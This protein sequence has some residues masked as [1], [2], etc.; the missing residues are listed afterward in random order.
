M[1]AFSQRSLLLCVALLGV[2]AI[3]ASSAQ[4]IT[5]TPTRT[6]VEGRARNPELRY[7][8]SAFRCDTG[9]ATGTTSDPASA[10]LSLTVAFRDNCNSFGFEVFVECRGNMTLEA[11]VAAGGGAG[12]GVLT[13][14]ADFTCSIRMTGICTITIRG[15]QNRLPRGE[16][17]PGSRAGETGTLEARVTTIEGREDPP[18]SVFC[19]DSDRRASFTARYAVTPGTIAIT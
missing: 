1:K 17:R 9:T 8:G 3:A 10:R 18:G 5:I 11:T 4:A 7:S 16:Y 2:F 19:P 6:R 12:Q 14:D 15:A 13:L